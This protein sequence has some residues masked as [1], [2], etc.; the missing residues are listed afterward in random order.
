MSYNRGKKV[1]NNKRSKEKLVLTTRKHYKE[2]ADKFK[3]SSVAMIEKDCVHFKCKVRGEFK[4]F[5][6]ELTKKMSNEFDSFIDSV[7]LSIGGRFTSEAKANLLNQ[8]NE[9]KTILTVI[10]DKN[11]SPIAVDFNSRSV[12][13][14]ITSGLV[15][16]RY[17]GKIGTY[18]NGFEKKIVMYFEDFDTANEWDDKWFDEENAH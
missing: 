9:G 17:N 16:N 2:N 5:I 7:C 12:V 13:N 4:I 15:W 3:A 10:L 1:K 11:D 8:Y 14:S 6:Y 18:K